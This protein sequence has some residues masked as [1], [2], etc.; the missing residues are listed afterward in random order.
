MQYSTV[1]HKGQITIP[2]D[3]R[4]ALGINEG[5]KVGFIKTGDTLTIAT[6]HKVDLMTLSGYLP[7]PKKALSIEAINR[8]I[9]DKE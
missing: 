2:I 9:E 1:T 8:I 3:M 7:K 5:D 4:K 6:M